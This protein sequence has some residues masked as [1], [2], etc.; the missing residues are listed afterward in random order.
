M[1]IT[2]VRTHVLEAKLSQPFAYSRAWYATRMAMIVEI[3]TDDDVVGWG[4]C[5][6]PA[7]MTAAVVK[8][9]SPMLIGA[10][11]L[12]TDWLWQEIYATLR[13]HGQ[14]GVVEKDARVTRAVREAMGSD[15]ALRYGE[16]T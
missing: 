12:R 8:S 15:V 13:D 9:V 6:G 1:K 14:K 10:D 16:G 5:Y 3:E 11:P 2:H 4:E 7:W